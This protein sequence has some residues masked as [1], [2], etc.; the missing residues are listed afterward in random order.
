MTHARAGAKDKAREC[1]QEVLA[2][3]NAS[4]DMREQAERLL[5]TLGSGPVPDMP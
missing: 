1:A 3:P 4:R 5:R 2:T